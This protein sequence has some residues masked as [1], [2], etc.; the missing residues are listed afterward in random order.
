MGMFARYEEVIYG[1]QGPGCEE[2]RGSGFLHSAHCLEPHHTHGIIVWM[3][4]TTRHVDSCTFP[5]P[6]GCEP[7]EEEDTPVSNWHPDE[8]WTP[9]YFQMREEQ[10]GRGLMTLTHRE[11]LHKLLD[12]DTLDR[13]THPGWV[14]TDEPVTGWCEQA[15]AHATVPAYL[16]GAVQEFIAGYS[17]TVRY[18]FMTSTIEIVF[19]M[20]AWNK[21]R[22]AHSWDEAYTTRELM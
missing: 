18:T 7:E 16:K 5:C 21:F 12:Q 9:S 10:A 4:G 2:C 20:T 8:D 19:D 3:E 11:R 22:F 6:N 17:L 14:T 15:E 1:Y 13:A